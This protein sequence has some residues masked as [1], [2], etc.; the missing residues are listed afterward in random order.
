VPEALAA[1]FKNQV[2]AGQGEVDV[3][4]ILTAAPQALRVIEFD[5]YTGDVFDGIAQSFAWLKENDK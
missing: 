1:A 2:P 4:G 5:D 3:R